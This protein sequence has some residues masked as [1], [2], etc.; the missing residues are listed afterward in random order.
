MNNKFRIYLLT[1]VLTINKINKQSMTSAT[2]SS[3]GCGNFNAIS[4]R[5]AV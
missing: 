4:D 3:N 5:A 2:E 1:Y